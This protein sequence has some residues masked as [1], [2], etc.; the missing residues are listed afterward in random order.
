MY[1]NRTYVSTECFYAI[2]C[3]PVFRLT[4]LLIPH[5]N[6]LI[7][8]PTQIPVHRRGP[9]TGISALFRR[10]TSQEFSFLCGAGYVEISELA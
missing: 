10:R 9:R 5:R 2:H 8:T 1:K 4:G 3:N 7:M 6:R